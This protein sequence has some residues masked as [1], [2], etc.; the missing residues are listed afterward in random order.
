MAAQHPSLAAPNAG[1]ANDAAGLMRQAEA[2]KTKGDMDLA[3]RLAQAAIVADPARPQAYDLLGDL[4]AGEGEGG[5]ARFYYNEALGIDPAD[6][7]AGRGITEL[8]HGG[9]QQ[10]AE[11]TPPGK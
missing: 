7:G 9:N 1:A 11:A 10:A 8:D 2:A 6:S 5:F 4:Y 3:L